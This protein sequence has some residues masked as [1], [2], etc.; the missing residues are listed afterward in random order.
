MN[1][2]QEFKT[3]NLS[4]EELSALTKELN[5]P[6]NDLAVQELLINPEEAGARVL[7]EFEAFEPEI[8]TAAAT[9]L[10][11]LSAPDQSG[12][13][14]YSIGDK[15]VS[16]LK[17]AW[18]H[19]EQDIAVLGRTGLEYSLALQDRDKLL[20]NIGQVLAI[21]QPLNEALFN[22]SL[23]A[24]AA[25]LILAIAD[26]YRADWYKS[27]LAEN[28]P[29][30]SYTIGEIDERLKN[31]TADFRWHLPFFT[32]ILPVNL[33]E[34]LPLEEVE[35]GLAELVAL[36]LL[37]ID[38]DKETGETPLY[39][40]GG[41][42]EFISDGLLNSIGKVALTI[43]NINENGKLAAE[44]VFF[45]RD[46]RHLWLTQISGN[47]GAVANIDQETFENII[48]ILTLL[49]EKPVQADLQAAS[50]KTSEADSIQT[51]PPQV[52]PPHLPKPEDWFIGVSGEVYGPHSR[53]QLKEMI[54]TG[55]LKPNSLVWTKGMSDWME[56]SKV[57]G[58]L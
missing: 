36:E 52:A 55:S 47:K 19:G 45:A 21:Y 56:L 27:A 15:S 28:L 35:A 43:S 25:L 29:L 12:M 33:S 10:K 38:G 57:D 46:D 18:V 26:C 58:L 1:Y 23:S 5:N 8:K 39:T 34:A 40:I 7:Q 42:L 48:H 13:L 44:A 49:P 41:E 17:L 6:L 51:A 37:K 9:A 4:A 22:V 20:A 2:D 24:T 31:S 11:I 3:L 30:G 14:T 54:A 50:F 16:R 53:E 32:Q